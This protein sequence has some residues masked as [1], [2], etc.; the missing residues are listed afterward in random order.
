MSNPAPGVVFVAGHDGRV[1]RRDQ[2]GWR[3]SLATSAPLRGLWM[4]SANDGFVVA[5]SGT[6]LRFNGTTWS[7]LTYVAGLGGAWGTS[8]SNVFFWTHD[9]VFRFDGVN[10]TRQSIGDGNRFY[11]SAVFGR[12][13]NDV[14]AMDFGHYCG[15]YGSSGGGR[16]LYRFDGT[17]WS[18]IT[19]DFGSLTPCFSAAWGRPGTPIFL[20]GPG[21]VAYVRDNSE[22]VRFIRRSTPC[23][24]SL[25]LLRLWLERTDLSDGLI[26]D[27]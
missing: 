6:V 12:S 13:E 23:H 20:A 2:S 8:A 26:C 21:Y 22:A 18:R 5:D 3:V 15:I 19:W 27:L 1:Y 17:N 16:E 10:F 24:Q 4:A 9:G 7:R 14:Y 11:P 25:L